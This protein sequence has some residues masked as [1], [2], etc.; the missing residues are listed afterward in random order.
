M[1]NVRNVRPFSRHMFKS[2][3]TFDLLTPLRA[4][5]CSV[6]RYRQRSL[7]PVW[8]ISRWIFSSDDSTFM[9]VSWKSPVYQP[10]CTYKSPKNLHMCKTRMIHLLKMR[11]FD[12]LLN[13]QGKVSLEKI[14]FIHLKINDAI[15]KKKNETIERK[16]ISNSDESDSE[17]L[18]IFSELTK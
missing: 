1:L 15:R 13:F 2:L 6:G 9:T 5:A 10:K 3:L 7:L 11:S 4:P 12:W 17:K 14:K 8:N 16:Y 18:K